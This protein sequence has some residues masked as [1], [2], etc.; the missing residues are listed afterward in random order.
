MI[1]KAVRAKS[2]KRSSIP[3]F[4][5][6]PRGVRLEKIVE[7]KG[8][9]RLKLRPIRLDDESRMIDFHGLLSPKSVCLRY[10]GYLGLD[11]RI[12]H[13][14]LVR[15]CTN[16]PEVYSI[17]IEQPAHRGTGVRILAVGRLVKT[18]EPYVAMFDLSICHEADFSKLADILLS[19]LIEL[20]RAFRFAILDGKFL[21]VDREGI[22]LC[23]RWDFAMQALPDEGTV[24]A[25]LKL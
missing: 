14:R 16:T 13:T 7:V 19:R 5:R 24:Q 21:E 4:S 15:V 23:R 20:G 9:S 22:E 12:S 3:D 17:V 2:A 18:P 11:R 6:R 10:F 8:F 25:V 1:K